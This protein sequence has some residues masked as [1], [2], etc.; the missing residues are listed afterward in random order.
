[1]YLMDEVVGKPR[2]CRTCATSASA[3]PRVLFIENHDSFSW[4]VIDALPFAREEICVVS[5][6]EA[7]TVLPT[8]ESSDVVVMGPGP[9]DPQRAGLVELVHEVA[10]RRLQFVGVCLGHQAL[11]L[12][13]GATLFRSTPTHGKRAIAQFH[14]GRSLEVMR[15]H[16]LSLTDVKSPL[17]VTASLADGTVMAVEHESL[18]MRGVQFHPDSFGTPFGRALLAELFNRAEKIETKFPSPARAPAQGEGPTVALS[19]LKDDFALLSPE[20]TNSTSWTLVDL[21]KPGDARVWFARAEGRAEALSGLAR[22]VH[23]ALDVAPAS[24]NV[25]LDDTGFLDGVRS[26]RERIAAGDVYQVNLTARASLGEVDGA[27]LLS[28][29]CA[30]GVPRF[31]AWVKSSRFGEFVS[32]SPELLVETAGQWVHVEPMKGTA[33]SAD[34][35]INS[36]KDRAEL[37]MITDLLRDD[38]HRLCE[39][40][41][42][43][44]TNERRLIPLAYAVQSVA[45]VEGTLRAGVSLHDVLNVVHPGGSVTGAPRRSALQII[46]ELERTPRGAY[47]GTLGLEMNGRSRFSLLIRTAER[48]PTHWQYGVGGGI[49]WDS[50]PEAELDEV[51]LKL[52]ALGGT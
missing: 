23:L 9:M 13:F 38:L 5:A 17:R 48:L 7:A 41:S 2:T 20:F 26:I 37:A 42:V 11:G 32:A 22:P 44:V 3:V 33:A 4:N 15:Y 36:E 19:S 50:S 45:D 46:A 47:C 28:R 40:R 14:D 10:K 8:L 39:A 30:R 29:L 21:T 31:A 24:L 35:L 34:Q 16:S 27:A 49:T 43:V 18:P 51:R 1:M 12:A 25:T 6:V 52:G